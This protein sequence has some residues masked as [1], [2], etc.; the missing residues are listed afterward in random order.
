M[1]KKIVI[2]GAGPTGLGAAHR[3][4]EKGMT[5]FVVL[6]RNDHVGGLSASFQ[7]EGY[8]VD[9]GG[10]V[11]FSHYPY[12]DEV[13]EKALGGQ[14]LQ[15]QR[16]A[17]V[18]M[19][20]RFIPY[21][22][23]N[24]IKDLPP[25]IMWE[26]VEGLLDADP[27]LPSFNFDEWIDTVFGAGIAKHF[28]RPYNFKVWAQPLKEMAKTWISERV[29]VIDIRRVLK[30]IILNISDS[31]WGPNN[32]FK[33]PLYGGTGGIFES[34]AKDIRPFIRFNTSVTYVD[35]TTKTLTLST[36]EKLGYDMLVNT[37]PLDTLV[38]NSDLPVELKDATKGLVHSGGFS[39]SLGFN[40]PLESDKRTKCWNYF[41][42][43][44]CPFYR[45]TYL[46]NYSPN[47]VPDVKKQFLLMCETS[48]SEHKK[49]N[50]ST[51]IDETIAGLVE[52][53]FIRAEDVALIEFKDLID[54]PY[55]YP[56]P[57]LH[58]D[59]ALET[60]MPALQSLQIF[61]RGRFGQWRYEVGNMDH[62]FMQGV[63]VVDY[64]FD[65]KPEETRFKN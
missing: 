54:I 4:K 59:K 15:H 26:C 9:I 35:T 60:L 13:I 11:L 14:Y 12:F 16:E 30:N 45:V 58:R 19:Q 49:H 62:S 50:A 8:T 7:R 63:E 61:S 47:M 48:Y 25:E 24:N 27:T 55:S 46:S 40:R 56:I 36:G 38:Q 42:E 10:H 22:F 37:S 1:Q 28:M 2:I 20:N 23:Q 41:P 57:S 17:W 39:V 32:M 33:F 65:E 34:I 44:N 3:L 43:T 5:D 18:W 31:S 29:S 51:I 64:L 21:P 6:E 52:S 53:Q